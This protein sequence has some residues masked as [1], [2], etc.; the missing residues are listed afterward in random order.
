ML[1]QA[2]I[3]IPLDELA[4]KLSRVSWHGTYIAACCPFHGDEHPSLL[5]YEDGYFRCLTCGVFGNHQKLQRKLSGEVKQVATTHQPTP[6][7]FTW[8][9]KYGT[10]ENVAYKAYNNGK[11]FPAL[12]VYIRQRICTA[13][14]IIQGKIGW[15]DGW[16]S[17]PVFDRDGDFVDLVV[18]AHPKKKTDIRYAI[19]PRKNRN[20]MHLYSPDWGFLDKSDEVYFPFGI[21]DAW[22]IYACGLPAVT[23]ITGQL[24]GPELLGD[25]RKLIYI[26]P[27]KDEIAGARRLKEK[28]DWRGR[29]LQLDYPDGTKDSNGIL[30]KHGVNL[31]K[32]LIEEAKHGIC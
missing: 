4:E 7:W 30:C 1:K 16:F 10:F 12:L 32:E 2:T 19:R 3:I 29:I 8:E 25:I 11:A 20:D 22:S 21:L 18:R 27:D 24:V 9:R 14:Y 17:F 31:L 23:G 15:L 6:P 13:R 5:V 28:L 26:I